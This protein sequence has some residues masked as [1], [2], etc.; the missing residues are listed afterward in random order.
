MVLMVRAFTRVERNGILRRDQSV[1]QICKC[2][3]LSGQLATVN[4]ELS[5]ATQHCA[6]FAM[7]SL[8]T[9]GTQIAAGVQSVC[10][11]DYQKLCGW[12]AIQ[13]PHFNV[14]LGQLS[15]FADG[16]GGAFHYTCASTDLYCDVQLNPT[17]NPVV[18][19][20]LMVAVAIE[21]FE[22]KLANGWACDA[23]NGEGLSRALAHECHPGA[24]DA[25]GYSTAAIWLDDLRSDWVNVTYQSDR[26]P[27]SHGCAVLF[28]NWLHHQLKIGWDKICQAGGATLGETYQPWEVL[29]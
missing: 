14:T 2:I 1:E 6:I 9:R 16:T 26:S 3:R 23:S 5:N 10:E 15:Q 19:A 4:A 7:P 20:A 18:S 8:G 27:Y 25:L 28:L 17:I 13:I 21:A 22:A 24:L 12:F 29:F 11:V